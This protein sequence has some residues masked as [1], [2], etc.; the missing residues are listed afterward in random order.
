MIADPLSAIS[1]G[2]T[3]GQVGPIEPETL[4]EQGFLL[5]PRIEQVYD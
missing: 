1:H 3:G 4:V 5:D 2:G